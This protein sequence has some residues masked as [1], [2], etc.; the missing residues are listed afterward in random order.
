M[1]AAIPSMNDSSDPVDTS[2][3][4]TL[5]VGSRG[6]PPRQL[7]QR[8]HAGRVVVGPRDDAGGGRSQAITAAAAAADTTPPA[9]RAR[10]LPAKEARAASSRTAEDRKHHRQA[11]VAALDQHGEP[12]PH[13][14][15]CSGMEESADRRR[16]ARPAPPSGASAGPHLRDHVEGVMHGQGP[17]GVVGAARD[18]VPDARG[19]GTRDRAARPGGCGRR[20]APR[21]PPPGRAG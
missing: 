11:R 5:V 21:R 2:S 20:P 7:E 15:R 6:Q 13:E 8:H 14:R 12:A 1:N 18:V 16:G 4:R 17:A 10:R 19:R 3:T 9:T